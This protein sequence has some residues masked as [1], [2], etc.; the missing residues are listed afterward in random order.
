MAERAGAVGMCAPVVV[1]RP[2]APPLLEQQV[3]IDV[4][5]RPPVAVREALRLGEQHAVLVDG[6]LTVPRQVGR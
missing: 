6:R 5:H 2:H 3:E 1:E 4:G